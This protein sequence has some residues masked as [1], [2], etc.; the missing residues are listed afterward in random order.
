ME[1]Y[2][3]SNHVD[4]DFKLSN[5]YIIE[6][7]GVVETKKGFR[8]SPNFPNRFPPAQK[9]SNGESPHPRIVVRSLSPY[10]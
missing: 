7:R 3:L 8:W 5:V 9:R 6:K 2:E 1:I 10:N 4:I